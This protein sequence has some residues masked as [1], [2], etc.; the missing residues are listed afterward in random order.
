MNIN[1]LQ[2]DYVKELNKEKPWDVYP[3]PQLVRDSYINLNGYFDYKITTNEGIVN[4][5]DG[6]ILVPFPIES[7]LSE[8]E[9]SLNENEYIYY[10]KD[11]TIP[12]EFVK[13]K[14]FLHFGAVDQ[15]TTI[16]VNDKYVGENKGGYIPF[17]FDIKNY[18][19]LTD[20]KKEYNFRLVVRVKDNL[21]L[22]YPY[23][24]QTKSRGGMWYTPVSGIWQTV[25]LE[26]VNNEYIES[27]KITPNIDDNT[28]NIKLFSS[29]KEFVIEIYDENENYNNLISSNNINTKDITIKL[30]NPIL[31]APENPHLYGIKIKTKFD[32]IKSYFGMRKIS[33]V[34]FNGKKVLALNNKPFF[35]NGLLDQGYFPDG[36]F[37][38]ATINGY[39]DDIKSMKELGFNTL[40]KHIKVEP[41]VWYYLC[42]KMGM[43]VWQDMVNNSLYSFF[44]DTVLPTIGRKS[45]CDKKVKISLENKEIFI[46][47]MKKT[48]ELLYN[49]PCIVLWTIFNEGWGQFESK[50][51]EKLLL[52]VDSTRLVDP[53]SGWFEQPDSK[54]NSLHIYFK[55]LKIKKKNV[56]IILSEFGGYSYKIN[57]HSYNLDK[58]YGYKFYTEQDKFEKAYVSLFENELIPL[59]KDGLCASIYTQ[60]SDVEDET[61]GILTYDRKI[62]KL[63]KEV[64]KKVNEKVKY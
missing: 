6:K 15:E 59:I 31:W 34:E 48:V 2:T 23:G 52:E 60:V 16:Y 61:N 38:P 29:C 27:I 55:K 37:L 42:D 25:W 46:S 40:R 49:N 32:E 17:K 3:R 54:I 30:E 11:V 43:I 50:R 58:T 51:M 35:F 7:S 24:K 45:R 1:K 33:I 47:H 18:I 62:C 26:S 21:D 10:K 19:K 14:L 64:I 22:K 13:D 53:T 20:D 12:S 56:P 4:D 57:E 5:F 28:I 8:V 36:L 44:Q 39:I 9:K 41:L 63:N